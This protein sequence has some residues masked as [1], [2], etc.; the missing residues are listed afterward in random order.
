[1]DEYQLRILDSNSRPVVIIDEYF[2]SDEDA[3][4]AAQRVARSRKFEVWR[5]ISP[6]RVNILESRRAILC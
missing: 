3:L 6:V 4:A 1:M 2:R 5:H